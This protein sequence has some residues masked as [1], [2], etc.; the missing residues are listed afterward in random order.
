MGEGR[1]LFDTR[2]DVTSEVGVAA[3]K[4]VRKGGEDVLEFSSVEVIP[5]TEEACA[6]EPIARNCFRERLSYR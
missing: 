5:R 2:D 6:E 3:C 1:V 4:L